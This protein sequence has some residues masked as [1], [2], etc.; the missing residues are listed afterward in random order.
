MLSFRAP[1]SALK[2]KNFQKLGVNIA[3]GL[4]PLA[5][6][7]SEVAVARFWGELQLVCEMC[8]RGTAVITAKLEA[9]RHRKKV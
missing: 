3:H 7:E 8:G 1:S 9:G 6:T 2:Q 4:R 5:N